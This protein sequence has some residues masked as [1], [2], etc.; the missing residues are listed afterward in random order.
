MPDICEI[1]RAA[2]CMEAGEHV[3]LQVPGE[4]GPY[5][6]TGYMSQNAVQFGMMRFCTRC[7]LVYWEPKNPSLEFTTIGGFEGPDD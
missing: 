1:A 6:W 5:T 3:P 7:G 2:E 4:S